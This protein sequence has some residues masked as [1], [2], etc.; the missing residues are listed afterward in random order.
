MIIGVLFIGA[1]QIDIDYRLYSR[2]SAQPC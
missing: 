2:I 1:F